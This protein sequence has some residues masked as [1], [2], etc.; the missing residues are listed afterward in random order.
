MGALRGGAILTG[1]F[2]LTLPLMPVQVALL[3]LSRQRARRFPHWYHK[4]VCRLLGLN[5]EI[6]GEVETDR[7]V[8]YL[9]IGD[10]T[11]GD[12]ATYSDVDLAAK[13]VDGKWVFTHKDGRSYK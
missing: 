12:A 3:R 8:L 6:E 13:L 2:A 4:R 9:E 11:P 7:P 1:F 5:I 10:R